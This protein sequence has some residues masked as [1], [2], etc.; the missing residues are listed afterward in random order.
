MKQQK[1]DTGFQKT[2][3][4]FK[5]YHQTSDFQLIEVFD[6]YLPFWKCEQNIVIEKDV[7]LDR[8]SRVILELIQLNVNKQEDLCKFLGI[9]VDSFVTMQFHFLLKNGL[10][11]ELVQGQYEITPEGL[12]F[13]ENKSKIRNINSVDF[14]YFVTEKTA[15]LKNDLTQEFFDSQ[16]PIDQEL[17]TGKIKAFSGYNLIQTHRLNELEGARKI[18]HKKQKPSFQNIVKQRNDF[19]KFFNN[20][21]Q[22]KN[23]YDFGEPELRAYQRSI[24]FIGL[25]YEDENGDQKLDIRQSKKS[26]KRFDGACHLERLL[27]QR[28]TKF[29]SKKRLE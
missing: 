19:S 2:W 16:L 10:I 13:L 27:S 17:S 24:C 23:F 8:F 21:F 20:Q 9:E 6:I 26:V 18:P 15:Y 3:T 22:D 12:N 5:D 4:K 28:A 7:D 11:T 29:I 1:I 14:E 25:L